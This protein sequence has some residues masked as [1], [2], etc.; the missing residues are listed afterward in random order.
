[1]SFYEMAYGFV[2]CDACSKRPEGTDLCSGCRWNKY[3]ATQLEKQTTQLDGLTPDRI[4]HEILC[5][6]ILKR[7]SAEE[8]VEE[9]E[10]QLRDAGKYSTVLEDHIVSLESE[11]ASLKPGT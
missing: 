9:A 7:R 10:K 1:V 6:E 8:R 11:L 5:G 2:E 4:R 3:R